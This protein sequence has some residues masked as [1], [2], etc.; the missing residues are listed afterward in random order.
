M[1]KASRRR[2]EHRRT[3]DRAERAD[4][5]RPT[6]FVTRPFEGLV[7]E[8]DWVAMREVVP[9]A[10][11]TAR[12]R[13]DA[14][15]G[16]GVG[17]R[18]VSVATVL[19]M[20]W[21]ALH[22]NDGT[23][24]VGLQG[25]N[26]SA[27]VSR[28]LAATL[29]AAAAAEQGTSI[30]VLPPVDADSPRLQDVLDPDV[31][32]TV[33]VHDGFDFWIAEGAEL[34]AEGAASLERANQAVIPTVKMAGAESAYWCRVGERTHLRW[35]LPYDEDAATSALARMYASDRAQLAPQT[36]LLGAFRADGLLVPVWDLDPGLEAD[37]YHDALTELAAT[38]ALAAAQDGP[39]DALERRARSGLLSR[40]VTLR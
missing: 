27:D 37:A 26:A 4:T 40:Q 1:G 8:A 36:R 3:T 24:F 2:Q 10:T 38:M 35:V 32:F 34:D 9:A 7:G 17:G 16:D 13:Q 25:G 14:P 18:E 23:L 11:A 31:P 12:L 33:S 21:P 29:L 28:D 20:A 5:G 15:G 30:D 19:P 39:L 6:P 22:R